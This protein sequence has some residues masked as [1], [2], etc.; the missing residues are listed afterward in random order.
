MYLKGIPMWERGTQKKH[1]SCLRSIT[2]T[3]SPLLCPQSC[4]SKR[5]RERGRRKCHLSHTYT[6]KNNQPDDEEQGETH[7]RRRLFF[8]GTLVSTRWWLLYVEMK[9]NEHTLLAK[10]GLSSRMIH[11]IPLTTDQTNCVNPISHFFTL[12][13]HFENW[14]RLHTHTHTFTHC[15]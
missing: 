14:G 8:W 4:S 10:A 6:H 12:L 1:T 11:L 7:T 3:H 13:G 5:R 2:N 15:L 9:G